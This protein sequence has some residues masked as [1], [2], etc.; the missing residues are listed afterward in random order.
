M[1]ELR[2]FREVWVHDFEY[3]AVP[4]EHVEVHCMVA[5]ELRSGRRLRL[6]RDQLQSPPYSMDSSSLFVSFNAAAELSAHLSLGWPPPIRILDL[7][8]EF[9]CLTN[10]L[11]LPDGR[12]L[13][14]ALSHFGLD[15]ISVAEKDEMRN[16][17]MRGA[18]FT[19]QEKRDLLNYCEQDVIAL[20][21]LLGRMWDKVNLPQAL[22]RGR[23][24]RAL[25][26]VEF[27]GT[28]IDHD[29]LLALRENW[30]AIK[31]DLIRAVDKDFGV[32][33]GTSLR[34]K[35]LARYART[36]SIRNWPLTDVG[37]LSKSDDTF[38][39][40][41][42]AYPQLQPLRELNYAL[43]KM[44]LEK[45]AV[46]QH[47]HHNRTP[48][49]AF[50]TKTSRNAP[51]A[52]EYI[53]SP[54]VWM[55]FLIR[56]E[57]GW[58]AEYRDYSAQEFAIASVLSDD[59]DMIRSY[60]TGD[61]YIAFGKAIGLLPATADKNSHSKE[62]D[63]LKLVLLG[64][65]Y[66]MQSKSLAAYSGQSDAAAK[67]ILAG[68]K[69]LYKQFWQWSDSILEQALLKGRICSCYGWQFRAPWKPAKPDKKKTKGVPIRSIKNW[70]VQTCAAEMLRLATCL[71]VE[72]G[73]M[74]CALVHD[75]VLY[76]APA[77][78]IE[79]DSTIVKTAMAEASKIILKDKLE[80]RTDGKPFFHP[81]RYND[82]RGEVMWNTVMKVLEKAQQRRQMAPPPAQ[83][84]MGFLL[85][86]QI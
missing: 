6:W 41:A 34:S 19:D 23:Y 84:E 40:M 72:K 49:W 5:H 35:L 13:L 12:G 61:P 65:L 24:M 44:R 83:I 21:K 54:S 45:L 55:R 86:G 17:A 78:R 76:T 69:R 79:H 31:L 8:Q 25:A 62:R 16:L 50:H 60:Q 9:K 81:T 10:G 4:G 71:M 70:P 67:R 32:Y 52:S 64:I 42:Q 28:P 26:M 7:Y 30:E 14:G 66:G 57:P 2:D 77:D 38:K 46:S 82:K 58:A 20:P 15:A 56:P 43:S 3:R 27:N 39:R 36:Q 59:K 33:D 68:H 75:A 63:R 73:V 53:F 74:V 47:D 29:T 22:H 1:A 18:P 80:L 85:E 51:K 11:V 48:L 37:K